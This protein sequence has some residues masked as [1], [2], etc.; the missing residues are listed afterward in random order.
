MYISLGESR[1]NGFMQW[2]DLQRPT[3]GGAEDVEESRG[4]VAPTSALTGPCTI[5]PAHPSLLTAE[6][7]L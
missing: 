4:I 1:K 5:L 7:S 3:C 2:S 6:K